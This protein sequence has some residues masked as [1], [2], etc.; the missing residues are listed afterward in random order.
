[1]EINKTKAV[2]FTGYRTSKIESSF[3]NFGSF[4]KIES[5]LLKEIIALYKSG[6]TT[7]ITGGSEGFDLIAALAILLA[8]EAY[9]DIKLV[10]AVPFVAQASKY[11]DIDKQKYK[12]VLEQADYVHHIS[13]NYYRGV[14]YTRN[15]YMLDNSAHLICYYNGLSGGT[16]YT[17]DGACKR[18]HNIINI[19]DAVNR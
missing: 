1:M 9:A 19:Y 11:S 2:A 3:K 10:V 4:N 16:K 18:N 13:K 5:E 12:W 17:Y 7:F 8:R 15:D 14:F 6:I